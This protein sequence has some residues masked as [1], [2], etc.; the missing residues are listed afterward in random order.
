MVSSSLAEATSLLHLSKLL[1]PGQIVRV[2]CYIGTRL[3]DVK[4]LSRI[5]KY[6]VDE[7]KYSSIDGKI[8]LSEINLIFERRSFVKKRV[9]VSPKLRIYSMFV[10]VF[11]DKSELALINSSGFG[12]DQFVVVD[13]SR[14]PHALEVREVEIFFREDGR[15]D[16]ASLSLPGFQESGFLRRAV[17]A[18]GE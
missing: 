3:T 17:K 11:A 4:D 7:S 2:D 10:L 14:K 6:L 9:L 1:N 8:L 13:L 15:E 18:D 12:V 5:G 16:V